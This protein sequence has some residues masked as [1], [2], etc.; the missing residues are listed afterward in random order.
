MVTISLCMIVK[1]EE[2]VLERCLSSVSQLADEIIIADTGSTDRTKEIAAK[3]TDQIFDFPWINDFS[4]ARNFVFEKATKDFILW[5]DADDIIMP[6]DRVKFKELKEELTEDTD[7]VMMRYNTAFDEQ[8]R[9]IFS[10]FRERLSKKSRNFKWKEPV[11]EYLEFGGVILHSE[12]AITHAKMKKTTSAR[13]VEIYESILERGEE[14]SPRGMYYYAR[15]LKDHERFDEAIK[16]FSQFLDSELGWVE[17]NISACIELAKC[18]QL[19][20]QPEK[21]LESMMRSF[22]Y[23]TPRGEACCQIGYY[24]K[25]QNKFHQAIFW[26][27]LVLKLKH[28]QNSWGFHQE[29][30]W[31]YIPSIEC[32]VCYDRL[33]DMEKAEYY[34]ELAGHYKPEDLAVL[35]NKKYFEEKRKEEKRRS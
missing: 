35:Y 26:F 21:A 32:A 18:Y 2:D 33:G 20:K 9:V 1:N 11:H 6:E 13:N 23:D 19:T 27:E 28:P 5:L 22:R 3:F 8:G 15:E 29:D 17:D 34:N 31:G 25:E 24:F 14:L 4:A 10:Y 12:A 7:I 16:M 30:F